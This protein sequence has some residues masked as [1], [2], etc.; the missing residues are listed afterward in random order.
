MLKKAAFTMH[1]NTDVPRARDFY[2]NKLGLRIGSHANRGDQWWIDYDLPG[3]GYFALTNFTE[4]KPSAAA[5]KATR[6]CCTN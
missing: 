2:E 3:G 4:E 5:A 6:S 1:P